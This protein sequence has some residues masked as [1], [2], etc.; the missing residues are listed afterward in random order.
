M[1][2]RQLECYKIHYDTWFYESTLHESGYV[3]ETVDLLTEKGW[4]YEKDG[5]LWLKTADILRDHFRKQGKKEA[6]IEKPVSYTHLDVYK[7]QVIHR[8]AAGIH[9]H[10]ARCV[11]GE[12]GFLMGGGVVKIHNIHPFRVFV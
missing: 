1:Y 7:R 3:A 10:M 2:K 4:T 9:F 11:G 8:G 5:A 6:D 12:F